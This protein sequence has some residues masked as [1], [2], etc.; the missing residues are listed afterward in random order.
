MLVVLAP[1]GVPLVRGTG[2]ALSAKKDRAWS[3]IVVHNRERR[4]LDYGFIAAGTLVLL[5]ALVLV[6]LAAL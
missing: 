5:L 2:A 1:S 4:L 6:S 3:T